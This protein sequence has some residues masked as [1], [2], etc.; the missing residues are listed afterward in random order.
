MTKKG[1]D[2]KE[3]KVKVMSYD[4][5]DELLKK[6]SVNIKNDNGYDKAYVAA[7]IKADNMGSSIE[8]EKHLALGIKDFLDDHDGYDE[9]AMRHWYCDMVSMGISI[10]WEELI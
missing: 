2:G 1:D 3:T 5:V 10:P 8:D 7:M 9:K 6:H 4:E